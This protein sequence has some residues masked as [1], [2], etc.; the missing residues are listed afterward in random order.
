MEE[1]AGVV[2][3][4]T[5]NRDGDGIPT[6]R[7]DTLDPPIDAQRG[8][9]SKRIPGAISE[10]PLPGCKDS[11]GGGYGRKRVGHADLIDCGMEN[12]RVAFVQ[13]SPPCYQSFLSPAHGVCGFDDGRCTAQFSEQAVGPITER[14]VV[15]IHPSM[16]A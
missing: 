5:G 15:V 6:V 13:S 7:T 10:P 2:D 9:D 11:M 16:L 4:T 8:H 3:S 12:Q 1:D 14:E